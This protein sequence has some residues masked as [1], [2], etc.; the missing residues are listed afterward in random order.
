MATAKLLTTLLVA[1]TAQRDCACDPSL[2]LACAE[3]RIAPWER[4]WRALRCDL[5]CCAE[6]ATRALGWDSVVAAKGQADPYGA[7]VGGRSLRPFCDGEP[8]WDRATGL[9]LPPPRRRRRRIA[10]PSSSTFAASD[11]APGRRATRSPPSPPKPPPAPEPSAALLIVA[12]DATFPPPGTAPV[13][14][15]DVWAANPAPA[16]RRCRWA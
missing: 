13:A 10:P 14:G 2:G 11:P 7:L 8:G 9:R 5:R 6:A 4:D 15:V 3:A 16:R 12:G 1:A